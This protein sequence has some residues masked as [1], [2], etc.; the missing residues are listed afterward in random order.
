MRIQP[1]GNNPYRAPCSVAEGQRERHLI[2][3][4]RHEHGDQGGADSSDV[5]LE[6]LDGQ[7][8]EEEQ[9]WESRCEGGQEQVAKRIKVLAPHRDLVSL[10]VFVLLLLDL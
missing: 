2:D 5:P 7:S 6:L 8:P 1:I 9:D 4:D 3:A 10:E